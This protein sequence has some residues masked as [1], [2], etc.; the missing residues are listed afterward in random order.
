M[1]RTPKESLMVTNSYFFVSSKL[2]IPA[3]LNF[4]FQSMQHLHS[5]QA[6]CEERPARLAGAKCG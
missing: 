1:N 6:E 2:H 5:S 3:I 4:I